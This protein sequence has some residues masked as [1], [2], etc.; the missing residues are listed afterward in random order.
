MK[1]TLSTRVQNIDLPSRPVE[2]CSDAPLS[3]QI[4]HH[5]AFSHVLADIAECNTGVPNGFFPT[6]GFISC[7]ENASNTHSSSMGSAV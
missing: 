7:P 5:A 4:S 3:H 6:L 2:V 1:I